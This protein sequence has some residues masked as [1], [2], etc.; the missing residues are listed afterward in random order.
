MLEGAGRD[1]E[2]DRYY[3]RAAAIPDMRK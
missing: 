1:E 3:E 2:A